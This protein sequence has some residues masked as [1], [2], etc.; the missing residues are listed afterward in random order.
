MT[1]YEYLAEKLCMKHSQAIFWA[2][3][4]LGAS[5]VLY[6]TWLC[7]SALIFMYRTG[8]H[9]NWFWHVWLLGLAAIGVDFVGN[10]IL[11]IGNAVRKVARERNADPSISRI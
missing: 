8:A 3:R 7:I 9:G 5:V 1:R 2:S 4:V 10:A 11:I 6:A